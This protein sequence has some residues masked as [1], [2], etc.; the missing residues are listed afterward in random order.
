MKTA[1][2]VTMD[3]RFL[4][5]NNEITKKIGIEPSVLLSLLADTD[6]YFDGT[7]FYKTAESVE[8]EIGMNKK[9]F[10]KNKKILVDKGLVKCWNGPGNKSYFQ[11]TNENL[12]NI[13]KLVEP[14]KSQIVTT[15]VPNCNHRSPEMELQKSKIVTTEVPNQ[16]LNNNKEQ[17]Q[18]RNNKKLEE[19]TNNKELITNRKNEELDEIDKWFAERNLEVSK[20][21]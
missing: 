8:N 9:A 19:I 7:S 2:K 6:D 14:Q 12:E 4:P 3:T 13:K 18:I 16:H 1:K 21:N 20:S 10:M 15:E 5:I 17:E 11:F